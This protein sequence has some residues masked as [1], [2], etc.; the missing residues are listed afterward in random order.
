MHSIA[1]S[2]SCSQ[3]T[4]LNV[5]C[6]L[7]SE[8]HR[9]FPNQKS[10]VSLYVLPID[11]PLHL[12]LNRFN[13]SLSATFASEVVNE[14]SLRGGRHHVCHRPNRH[15]SEGNS[16]SSHT[17][18]EKGDGDNF[19]DI[20]TLSCVL[21]MKSTIN[22]GEYLMPFLTSAA[23]V[24]SKHPHREDV[25]IVGVK[26]LRLL[27]HIHSKLTSLLWHT[28]THTVAKKRNRVLAFTKDCAETP[29][30]S[31]SAP[32]YAITVKGEDGL[33]NHIQND[34]ESEGS[35]S[36]AENKA[37]NTCYLHELMY[38]A[39]PGCM[40]GIPRMRQPC[41]DPVCAATTQEIVHLSFWSLTEYVVC[42][43]AY[44]IV[45]HR[46]NRP[47]WDSRLYPAD[48]G[49]CRL[50]RRNY[51]TLPQSNTDFVLDRIKFVN[52]YNGQFHDPQSCSTIPLQGI[53]S[54]QKCYNICKTVNTPQDELP[55]MPPVY[56][57]LMP[58][59]VHLHP[60][61]SQKNT[62]AENSQ[63]SETRGGKGSS[64][65]NVCDEP[66]STVILNV[67]DK[68]KV[69]HVSM[70]DRGIT[71]SQNLFV[72][73]WMA[74]G[75]ST[76]FVAHTSSIWMPP[77]RCTITRYR[78][79]TKHFLGK[80]VH[81]LNINLCGN[82]MSVF[83]ACSV[84]ECHARQSVPG[85][86][87]LRTIPFSECVLNNCSTLDVHHI[88]NRQT[89]CQRYLSTAN[90]TQH[91][92]TSAS[93]I[94]RHKSDD[95]ASHT[96]KRMQRRRHTKKKKV[97][98]FSKLKALKMNNFPSYNTYVSSAS[99]ISRRKLQMHWNS[100]NTTKWFGNDQKTSMQAELNNMAQATAAD[101]KS[102]IEH[103]A[104]TG[105]LLTEFERTNQSLLPRHSITA[106]HLLTIIDGTGNEA[107]GRH[108][109]FLKDIHVSR[110]IIANA[111]TFAY[112]GMSGRSYY[113]DRLSYVSSKYNMNN[114]MQSFT[115]DM[116][117]LDELTT[118]I[119]SLDIGHYHTA[120]N[121]WKIAKQDFLSAMSK[122][123]NITGIL[124][125]AEKVDKS[126]ILKSRT[127]RN[128]GLQGL[129]MFGTRAFL[130]EVAL[131]HINELKAYI[132]GL[133]FGSQSKQIMSI[134]LKH[135]QHPKYA[136]PSQTHK[137]TSSALTDK[138]VHC[139]IRKH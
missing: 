3:E 73:N 33:L 82:G 102:V 19:L 74:P 34:S 28:V 57:N 26:S 136:D 47:L 137:L 72:E 44:N 59:E 128:V 112:D 125:A 76:A 63:T 132:D 5:I 69:F 61:V 94:E 21:G 17:R 31:A 12:I 119:P 35:F 45:T 114:V 56:G 98:I 67:V 101:G 117:M 116:D 100:I 16:G 97:S 85:L 110:D 115:L 133:P 60:S 4:F 135:L 83:L 27:A 131:H 42:L 37:S 48:S 96:F 41:S 81:M 8:M 13:A 32:V 103:D 29:Q 22:D 138:C 53:D 118:T 58:C 126:V 130:K 92:A 66:E 39:R 95:K 46:T 122:G 50:V 2:G 93:A 78:K 68:N 23:N 121:A 84:Y 79:T 75:P 25:T 55:L 11:Q 77:L 30:K 40:D 123:A 124:E 65:D 64:C 106:I 9:L 38:P 129:F 91:F 139:L 71:G 87:T 1:R 89:Y 120:L 54:L 7:L 49:T 6:R 52:M 70:T 111:G 127:C 18:Q 108:K 99:G 14:I 15:I 88:T 62:A 10:I 86:C 107:T 80:D 104:R 134:I 90:M 113:R 105:R 109:R 43:A 51:S 24:F 20:E 36:D